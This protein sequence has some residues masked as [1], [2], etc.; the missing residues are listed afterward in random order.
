MPFVGQDG[1]TDFVCGTVIPGKRESV[2]REL[3]RDR[4]AQFNSRLRT[5][6]GLIAMRQALQSSSRALQVFRS[7]TTAG[8]E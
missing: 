5:S 2:W 7:R 3:V 1:D 4:T 8:A 6:P